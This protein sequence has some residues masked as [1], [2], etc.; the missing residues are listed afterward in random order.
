MRA[1]NQR[2][3]EYKFLVLTIF[4]TKGNRVYQDGRNNMNKAEK[5]DL[6]LGSL[7]WIIWVNLISSWGP[8]NREARGQRK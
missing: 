4:Q 7:C 5:I 6:E 2:A 8:Y 3:P 1:K